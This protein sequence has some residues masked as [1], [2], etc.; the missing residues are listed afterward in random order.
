MAS[1]AFAADAVTYMRV[2]TIDGKIVKYDVEK[3]T[4]VDFE[5][6][7]ENPDEGVTVS[8]K[9]GLYTYVDLGLESGAKWATCNVGASKPTEYGDY[10]AWGETE[11]KEDY[12]IEN[13]KWCDGTYDNMTKYDYL[14]DEKFELDA[15][16]DAASANWGSAWRMP[17]T[18]ELKELLDG[19]EW[20]WVEDFNGSG[21]KGQLGTSKANGATIFLPAAGYRYD[22]DLLYDGFYG[23]YW[24]PSNYE[25]VTDI[26]FHL[27]F[28]DTKIDWLTRPRFVGHSV[29]AVLR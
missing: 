24:S 29:R 17:T 11:T 3:V 1:L 13:Y 15:E 2:H 23:F 22:T 12:S 16:D 20:V 4:E 7:T 18:A 19:C 26:A 28:N 6:S 25:D 5:E 8:G 21:V 9:E 14:V 10:F 27:Q